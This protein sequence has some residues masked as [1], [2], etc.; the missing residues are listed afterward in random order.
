MATL[1]TPAISVLIYNDSDSMLV[2][3]T[4]WA[5]SSYYLLTPKTVDQIDKIGTATFSLLD[6]GEATATE[7]SLRQ[8]GNYVL[9][10]LGNA[11][12]FSGR[13]RRVTQNTQ[14]GYDT[15]TRIKQWDVECDSDLARLQSSKVAASVLSTYGSTIYGNAGYIAGLILTPNSGER[16]V[17]G[18]IS[19]IGNKMFYNLNTSTSTE[20]VG[21]K[22]DHITLLQSQTNFDLRCRSDDFYFAYNSYSAGVLTFTGAS[23][24]TDEFVGMYVLFCATST[25]NGVMTYGVVTDNDATTITITPVGGANAAATGYVLIHKGF[26]VDFSQDLSQASAIKNFD[27]NKD[28]FDFSDNDDKRKLITKIS[29]DGKDNSGKTINVSLAAVH[30]YDETTQFFKDSTFITY[31]TDAY[32]YKNGYL[33][34]QGGGVYTL[35]ND[36]PSNE[37]WLYGWDIIGLAYDVSAHKY[38]IVFPYSSATSFNLFSI[39]S[40]FTDASGVKYSKVILAGAATFSKDYSGGAYLLAS[41]F[42]VDD[43]SVIGTNACLIG[44]EPL[45]ISAVGT[46]GTYG[47]YL[48]IATPP[49]NRLM[50]TT[51]KSYPHGVGALVAR[52]NYTEASPESD[53]AIALYGKYQETRTVDTNTTFGDLEA[54][55]TNLL[56]G[57]GNFYKKATCWG[58]VV[59]DTV[60]I[61]GSTY[62]GVTEPNRNVP[63]RPCDR[64]SFTE[65]TGA[66]AVEYQTVGITIDMDS[67]IISY[68]LGDYEKNVFTS[69]KQNT[70]GINNTLS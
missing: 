29:V 51:K 44:E 19:S 31:K 38:A 64:L 16:D 69:L 36:I 60:P 21:S 65:Y 4:P 18:T 50:G 10:V 34:N 5:G 55:A 28:V 46:D 39:T 27:V 37:M 45:T 41:R 68:E 22:Y 1:T 26:L 54:Y 23:F 59:L 8:E 42:Y 14:N 9:F 2:N 67:Q 47:D 33:V 58:P 56:L 32:I 40:G 25:Q 12:I 6:L 7:I 63:P 62:K 52:T 49:T 66:T 13:I 61:T 15:T 17:R 3:R 43:N 30:G 70:S 24:D 48:E 11:V 57:L 35:A 20:D 53:S